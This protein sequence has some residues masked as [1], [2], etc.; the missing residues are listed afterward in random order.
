MFHSG[1]LGYLFAV[2]L[3]CRFL[4]FSI[5]AEILSEA[6]SDFKY[7]VLHHEG[8]SMCS[9]Y[10]TSSNR[11]FSILTC[12]I[13]YMNIAT[14]NARYNIINPFANCDVT[15]KL[16]YSLTHSKLHPININTI[17]LPSQI[18]QNLI[19]QSHQIQNY[20]VLQNLILQYLITLSQIPHL[21]PVL[22]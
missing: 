19:P 13:L 20:L 5:T 1:L 3:S 9:N 14:H 17:I 8:A 21:T 16:L 10:C 7:C 15:L 11:K 12:H 22:H 2:C 6:H 4:N 18:L